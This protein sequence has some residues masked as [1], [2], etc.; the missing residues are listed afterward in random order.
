M[1]AKE[2]AQDFTAATGK[3]I[4]RQ[5]VSRCLAKSIY[6]QRPMEYVPLKLSQKRARFLWIQE[7]VSWAHQEWGY[8]LF[9]DK[10]GYSTNGDFCRVLIRREPGTRYHLSNIRESDRF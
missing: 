9:I 3:K 7:H 6:A 10:F 4:S 8:L 2:L 1:I 5:T